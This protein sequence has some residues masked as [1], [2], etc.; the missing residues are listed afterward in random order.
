MGMKR[1]TGSSIRVSPSTRRR[2]SRLAAKLNVSSQQEVIERALDKLEH[3]IFW[4]GFDEEAKAYL[5]AFPD[6][7]RER[8]LFGHTSIDGIR[9]KH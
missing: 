2:V 7:Y 9:A 5:E 6:E 1:G 3:T 8:A 4:E